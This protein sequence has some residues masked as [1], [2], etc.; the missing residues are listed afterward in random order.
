MVVTAWKEGEDPMKWVAETGKLKFSIVNGV[1]E[2]KKN[3]RKV[4]D[5]ENFNIFY[6]ILVEIITI[7]GGEHG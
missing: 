2:K 1:R 3:M 7:G 5:S 4:Y 6:C